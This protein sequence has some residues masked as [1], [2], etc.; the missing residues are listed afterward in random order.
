MPIPFVPHDNQPKSSFLGLRISIAFHATFL[1]VLAAIN[2]TQQT[3]DKPA[4]FVEV[5]TVTL[6]PELQPQHSVAPTRAQAQPMSLSS[7]KPL[8]API[9]K[10]TK[11]HETPKTKVKARVPKQTSHALS[12]MP[13]P[14]SNSN[15]ITSSNKGNSE[16]SL[17]TLG[18]DHNAKGGTGGGTGMGGG[19]GAGSGGASGAHN[20]VVLSRVTPR[21]PPNAQSRG[22]QGWVQVEIAVNSAG[23]VSN[24]KIVD[25]NPKYIFDQSALEAIKRWRFKP[26][27]K[28]GRPVGQKAKLKLVFRLKPHR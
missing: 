8:A 13:E 9:P 18:S 23:T 20:L 27:Q 19:S 5:A 17:T 6:S 4:Q 25:A 3:E 11:K 21:Y 2:P 28:E 26:A 1:C 12:K 16:N 14:D 15:L 24:A 22:V 7:P 10:K